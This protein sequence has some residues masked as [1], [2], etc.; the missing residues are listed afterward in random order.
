MKQPPQAPQAIVQNKET[1][2]Y[3]IQQGIPAE[4]PE[5]RTG[6]V[7]GIFSIICGVIS[8]LFYPIIFGPIGIVLGVMSKKRGSRKL[9]VTGIVLSAIFMSLGIFLGLLLYDGAETGGMVLFG[10]L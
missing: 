4:L 1:Q 8:L 6:R 9:G 5:E 2:A 7:V 10:L 3:Y